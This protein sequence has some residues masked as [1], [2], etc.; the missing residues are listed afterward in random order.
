MEHLL[1]T[2]LYYIAIN[3]L[4]GLLN[5]FVFRHY[6]GKKNELV[7]R[8]GDVVDHVFLFLFILYFTQLLSRI[9]DFYSDVQLEKAHQE[10]NRERVQ[11]LP[12]IKEIAKLLLWTLSVFWVMGSV[13]HVNIP[14]LITGLGIG[15]VAIAL[16]GKETVEN[17]FAAFTILTDKPF[18]TGETIKVGDI[19]GEVEKIGFRS[20]RVRGGDGSSFIIPNQTLVSQNLINLTQRDTRGMKL[21]VNIKYGVSHAALQQMITEL[22]A[23]VQQNLHI[24]EPI[25]VTL[26]SFGVETFQVV[27][28]YHVPNPLPANVTIDEVKQ[29]INLQTYDIV[30]KYAAPVSVTVPITPK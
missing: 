1:E 10:N 22:K 24:K 20:T 30:T 7:I 19:E 14:A 6:T 12:L 11:L 16:A 3:Q 8:L 15:G 2:V 9:I 27:I 4:S 26:E 18:Q 28:T 23:M 29:K 5:Q 25:E 21:V 13:F 17:F